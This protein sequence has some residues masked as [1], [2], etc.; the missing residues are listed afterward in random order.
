MFAHDIFKLNLF[1]NND[2][3]QI[4]NYLRRCYRK[5]WATR[6][7]EY[8]GNKYRK[9]QLKYSISDKGLSVLESVVQ[10]IS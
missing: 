1:A 10:K 6:K 3:Y 2:L 7:K 9:F 5:G 4:M 8:Q